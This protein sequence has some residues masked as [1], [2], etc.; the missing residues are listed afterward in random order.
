MEK[1]CILFTGLQASGETTFYRQR[2]QDLMHVNPDTLHTRN[3]ERLLMDECFAAGS[4]FVVDNTNP[5]G[6]VR[7]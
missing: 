5:T 7:A 3:K 1:K 2:F 4:S 6:E